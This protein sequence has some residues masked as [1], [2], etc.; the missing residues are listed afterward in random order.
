M[1]WKKFPLIGLTLLLATLL[2]AL[3]VWPTTAN[4]DPR[5]DWP[6]GEN[7]KPKRELKYC[8]TG[9]DAGFTS[10]VDAAAA[11][12][13]AEALGWT[14][15][16]VA[17]CAQ[18]DITVGQDNMGGAAA[19]GSI[20]LGSCL[21]NGSAGAWSG[22]ATGG[23]IN[24][25]NNAAANWGTP[26]AG[27]NRVRTIM[28]E[29]GHAMRLDH[30]FGAGDIMKQST[31][32]VAGTAL[33]DEDRK[34]A[35]T[36]AQY[37]IG[38][39]RVANHVAPTGGFG[40][41]TI[42]PLLG[43]EADV[44]L[45]GAAYITITPF[46]PVMHVGEVLFTP[47]FIEAQVHEFTPDI[48]H[49][50]GVT[51]TITYA[52]KLPPAHFHAELIFT[53]EPLMPGALPHAHFVMTPTGIAMADTLIRLDARESF[54]AQPG[55]ERLIYRWEIADLTGGRFWQTQDEYA[56]LFLPVGSYHISL[57]VEDIWGQE[58]RT[59]PHPLTVQTPPP[60]ATLCTE[61]G[62]P[63][64]EAALRA[65]L[66]RYIPHYHSTLLVFSQCYAGDMVDSFAGRANTGI[67]AGNM[68]GRPTY[69]GGYH[70][71]AAR[72]LR[73]ESGR[74]SADVHADGVSGKAGLEVPFTAGDVISLA[75]V[76]P[77]GDIRSRHVLVYGGCRSANPE[78]TARDIADRD[79][80]KANF[81]SD[82]HTT[83]T[84]VG[85]DGPTS[86]PGGWDYPGTLE[87]L[88]QALEHISGMMDS[89]EQFILF[90]TDHGD[91][92]PAQT[93]VPP[94][95][96]GTSTPITL[97][98]PTT[99][100]G[101]MLNDPYNEQGPFHV[102]GT[103]ITLFTP[104]IPAADIALTLTLATTTT[105]YTSPLM[106][107]YDFTGDGIPNQPGEGYYIHFRVPESV[108]IPATVPEMTYS[109]PI[110]ISYNN[111]M[112]STLLYLQYVSF[113]SG[114]IA[115]REEMQIYLPL[116]LRNFFN[117]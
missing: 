105:V 60:Y 106:L 58:D 81:A 107:P 68:P 11:A 63:I 20:T 50:E 108:L 97:D 19:D 10:D 77:T 102:A 22:T 117:P 9:D 4:V 40:W 78:H 25:N 99:L 47:D 28:H 66:D 18:A 39:L 29:F 2:M 64:T 6:T 101:D 96:P 80:I 51:V 54:H 27:R 30:T 111:P 62:P 56:A 42:R 67:L 3:V 92:H 70:D 61:Q 37:T 57:V 84:A 16:K 72:G 95:Q 115:R 53:D 79:A 74:T 91:L 24:I 35:R 94:L 26:P 86:I 83:V 21:V 75:P 32:N 69:Y 65:M 8:V 49:H 109:L 55:E 15:T 103:G 1:R 85:M 46:F 34:E 36:A 33:S 114:P 88:R 45:V 100:I 23:T 5:F 76:N 90:V 14:L 110:T 31:S 41:F 44:N 87:G 13:N 17:D 38:G 82:P 93:D 98:I 43:A 89:H 116:V 48:G 7:G 59:P 73:A 104:D 52:D 113:D 12:W 71:D 112:D